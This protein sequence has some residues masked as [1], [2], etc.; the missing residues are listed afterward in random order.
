MLATIDLGVWSPSFFR[1]ATGLF[2]HIRGIEPA[3]QVSAAEFALG[4][5]FVAGALSRL[6]DLHFVMGKLRRSSHG[7]GGSQ[8]LSS[9][10][11]PRAAGFTD[12]FYSKV[13]RRS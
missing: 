1:V 8:G 13:F 3:L 9:S 10:L 7:L 5:V 2:D 6:L 4:V 12:S 11:R